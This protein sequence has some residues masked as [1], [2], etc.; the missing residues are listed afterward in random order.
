MRAT[1]TIRLNLGCG[2][3]APSGWV[4]VDGSWNARLA[5]YPTIRRVLSRLSL[6]PSGKEEIPWSSSI[7]IHNMRKPLPFPDGSASAIYTSHLLEHLYLE[8]GQNLMTECFRVLQPGGVL[9]VV[10]PDLRAIVDEY[11][12]NGTSTSKA[13]DS[14][15][16]RPAELFN[17][18][19]LMRWPTPASSNLLYRIYTAWQ[20]F[21]SHK[22]MYD[23]DSLGTLFVRTGFVEVEPRD[24]FQSRIS[25]IDKVEDPSR[26]RNGEGVCV[27]GVKPTA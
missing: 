5:K 23:E 12:G 27:E 2:L 22:W 21:H 9:R 3:C 25:D 8:D 14:K 10:V 6:V 16:L 17:Q 19:L 1:E 13:T 11:L 20:D 4:N 7:F 26:I 24:C 18:R 15:S